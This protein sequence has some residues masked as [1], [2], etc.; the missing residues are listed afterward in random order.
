MGVGKWE[1]VLDD[2]ESIEESG[3]YFLEYAFGVFRN[4][5]H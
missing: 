2:W 3:M 1:Y 4:R 5:K